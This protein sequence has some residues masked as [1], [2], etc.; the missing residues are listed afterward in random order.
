MLLTL[1]VSRFNMLYATSFLSIN[2]VEGVFGRL[3]FPLQDL[4]L[5]LVKAVQPALVADSSSS[6]KYK[7]LTFTRNFRLLVVLLHENGSVQL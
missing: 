4:V 1:N 5:G 6:S 3:H 2:G 7:N